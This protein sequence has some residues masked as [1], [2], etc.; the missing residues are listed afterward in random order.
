MSGSIGSR[1]RGIGRGAHA[2]I[3]PSPSSTRFGGGDRDGHGEAQRLRW[4][5]TPRLRP[6]IPADP[7]RDGGG[8]ATGI[9]GA[10]A[11]QASDPALLGDEAAKGVK[12]SGVDTLPGKLSASGDEAGH[13]LAFV[14]LGPM[15]AQRPG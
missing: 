9:I 7:R 12:V 2:S 5:V 8:P 3:Y 10:A 1:A 4:A 6:R 13:L 14:W 15:P 11:G